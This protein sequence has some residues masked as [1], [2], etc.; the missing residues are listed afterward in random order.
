MAASLNDSAR[1]KGASPSPLKVNPNLVPKG[2]GPKRHQQIQPLKNSRQSKESKLQNSTPDIA[3]DIQVRGSQQS[4][5]L[6][7]DSQPGKNSI[8]TTKVL[9]SANI[10]ESSLS[11]NQQDA[12][13]LVQGAEVQPSLPDS[14]SAISSIKEESKLSSSKPVTIPTSNSAL[15]GQ[16]QQ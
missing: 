14:K 3:E 1:R 13:I 11:M 15:T 16:Q 2:L 5:D 12:K 4:S 8:D 10:G 9:V 7:L 6:L